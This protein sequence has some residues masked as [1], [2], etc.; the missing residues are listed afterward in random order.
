MFHNHVGI[1]NVVGEVPLIEP[2]MDGP[3]Q[4]RREPTVRDT[5][6]DCQACDLSRI[7]LFA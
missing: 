4:P 3:H 7:G 1:A 2:L 5:W 6:S